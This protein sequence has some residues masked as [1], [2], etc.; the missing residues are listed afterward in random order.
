LERERESENKKEKNEWSLGLES[1]WTCVVGG[2]MGT[3]V[4]KGKK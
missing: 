1:R 4:G 2:G 3:V